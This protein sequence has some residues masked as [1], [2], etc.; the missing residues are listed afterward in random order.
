VS[1][2]A[3]WGGINGNGNHSFT[4]AVKRGMIESL[5]LKW[6]PASQFELTEFFTGSYPQDG[7]RMQRL[8]LISPTVRR[9]RTPSADADSAALIVSALTVFGGVVM[10]EF[11]LPLIRVSAETLLLI[12]L[13]T[14]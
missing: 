4:I 1:T 6:W 2:G 11:I 12:G 14:Q 3:H 8:F 10:A 13:S 9:G 7:P 5:P